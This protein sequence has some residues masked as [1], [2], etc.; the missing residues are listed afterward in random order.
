M[1]CLYG[2][3]VKNTACDR[4]IAGFRFVQRSVFKC[5]RSVCGL[6]VGKL[7]LLR[8][9]HIEIGTIEYVGLSPT[10]IYE[11]N[12]IGE[13]LDLLKYWYM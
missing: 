3:V 11:E 6:A 13:V 12:K 7:M 9:L 8:S 5:P 1:M 2:S 4:Q 10:L